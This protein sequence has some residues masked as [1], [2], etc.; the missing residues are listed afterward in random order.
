MR[1]LNAH[2][3]WPE[4]LDRLLAAY[5]RQPLAQEIEIGVGAAVWAGLVFVVV[6]FGGLTTT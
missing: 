2:I 3:H 5:L 6:H 4:K 1:T